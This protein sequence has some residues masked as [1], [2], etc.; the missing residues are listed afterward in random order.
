MR[1]A[2]RCATGA[3][4]AAAAFLGAAST[5][6]DTQFNV[7]LTIGAAG[8]GFEHKIW[9]ETDFHFGLKTDLL[10]GRSKNSDFGFGPYAE[11][12]T[13]ALSELHFGGGGSLLLPLSDSLPLVISFGP[14]GRKGPEGFPVEPGLAW[15]LFW[16]SRSYNFHAS[17]ALTAGLIAQLRYGF[18]DTRQTAIVLG[19]RIDTVMLALPFLFLINAARGGSHDTD[20]VK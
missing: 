18:G 15:E 14:Y 17:Y 4:F 19:A 3:L 10:F 12:Q 20:P 1:L 6:A 16:G 5:N 13:I 2:A 8:V 7:G 11:L 9:R